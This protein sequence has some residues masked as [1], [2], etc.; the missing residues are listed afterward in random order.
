MCNEPRYA[1]FQFINKVGQFLIKYFLTEQD[2]LFG[3]AELRETAQVAVQELNCIVE[4]I[5]ILAQDF[6]DRIETLDQSLNK[7]RKDIAYISTD[8]KFYQHKVDMKQCKPLS[9]AKAELTTLRPFEK[10]SEDLYEPKKFTIKYDELDHIGGI[11]DTPTKKKPIEKPPR[12]HPPKEKG[13]A[14]PCPVH[15]N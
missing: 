13:C 14:D 9:I 8:T 3:S 2:E 15:R 7:M 5:E 4:N 6:K 12:K 10:I 11:T 1:I